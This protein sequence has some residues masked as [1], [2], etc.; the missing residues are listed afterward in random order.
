MIRNIKHGGLRRLY[1]KHDR[2]GLRPDIADKA[3]LYLSAL[4]TAEN[5]GELDITGFG[6]HALRGNLR[7]LYSVSVSRNHRI[8]FGFENGEAFD[9][10]LVDYH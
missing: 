9:V 10:D 4:D 2:S 3:E 1:Q 6:F 5:V 7:G 8:I